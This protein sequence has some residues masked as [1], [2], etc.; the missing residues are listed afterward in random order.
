MEDGGREEEDWSVEWVLRREVE[1][2]VLVLDCFSGSGWFAVGRGHT[3][4]VGLSNMVLRRFGWWL[5]DR[6][7][8]GFRV[9]VSISESG[10]LESSR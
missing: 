6:R 8:W 5:G 10:L 4:G 1:V 7:E 2:L 3:V 9:G